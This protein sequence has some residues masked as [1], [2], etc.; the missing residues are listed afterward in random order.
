MSAIVDSRAKLF[1]YI[2]LPTTADMKTFFTIKSPLLSLPIT[3][4][5][6]SVLFFSF[7]KFNKNLQLAKLDS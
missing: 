6:F 2:T 7:N 5:R 1:H 4:P 3:T